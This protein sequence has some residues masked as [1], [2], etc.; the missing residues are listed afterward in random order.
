MAEIH[1]RDTDIIYVLEGSATLVTG[2]TAL[3]QK[4]VALDEVRGTEIQNGESRHIS[5]G[6]VIVVPKGFAAL[7]PEGGEP[8]PVYVVKASS[9]GGIPK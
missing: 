6:D 1:I 7:V 4:T 3:H 2:G 8:A 9:P 5:K